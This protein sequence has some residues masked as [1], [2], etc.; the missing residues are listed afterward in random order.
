MPGSDPTARPEG[1]AVVL[2]AGY[3]GL[4]VAQG[5]A[6]RSRGRLPVVLVDR[7]P[8]HVLRT[9]L[10]EIGRLARAGADTGAWTLPL[11]RVLDRRSVEFRTG[12][13]RAIDLPG[14][15]VTLD[16]GPLPFGY[17][18]IGLGNVAAYYGVPGAAVRR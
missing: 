10:Y 18:A 12:E 15:S 6:R 5:I 1:P 3:A 14:R 7:H 16:S 4:A 2:G 17:L 9:E 11:A 8:V 13:V